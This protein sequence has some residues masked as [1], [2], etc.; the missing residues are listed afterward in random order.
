MLNA[1]KGYLTGKGNTR[2]IKIM[3]LFFCQ[4]LK[5]IYPI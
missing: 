4:L 5:V 3:H 2:V 1:S